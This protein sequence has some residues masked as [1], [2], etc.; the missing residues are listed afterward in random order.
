MTAAPFRDVRAELAQALVRPVRWRETMLALY[1]AGARRFLDL[2]PD[3]VL[4]R[5]VTRN[6]QGVEGIALIDRE[7]E[8]AAG[9]VLA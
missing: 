8:E 9:G 3:K 2:G 7:S 6:L 4:A 5:L 1:A